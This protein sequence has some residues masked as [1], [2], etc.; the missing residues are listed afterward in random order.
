MQFPHL[1]PVA[2]SFGSLVIRWYALAYVAGLIAGWRWSMALAREDANAP[3]AALYDEFLTW[4]VGGVLLG[5]R[6][7]Y[8]LFYNA[9]EYMAHPLEVLK[10]WHG[11]MSFHGGMTGVILAAILFTGR[12]KVS[13]LAFTDLL[14]CVTPI[15]LGLGRLA[16][17]V[18]GELYGRVTDVPW[19]IIFPRGG[20]LPRHP[21]QLYEALAEGLLLLLIMFVLSRQP[22]IRARAGVLSGAFLLLYGSMRFGIEFFREPDAQLGFLFAGATMGQLLCVPMIVAGAG[23]IAWALRKRA[24]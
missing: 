9:A 2:L 5:G 14:A 11:G 20:D 22:K 4:A 19:G 21:S 13:F 3:Q 8:V 7:A 16:N 17:F 23:I 24:V 10:I 18:N 1:D 6:I 15:G 12:H